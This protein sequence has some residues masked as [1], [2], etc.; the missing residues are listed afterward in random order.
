MMNAKQ[1]SEEVVAVAMPVKLTQDEEGLVVRFGM[2]PDQARVQSALNKEGRRQQWLE[3]AIDPWAKKHG[4]SRMQ[5]I[6]VLFCDNTD[7]VTDKNAYWA[8][9]NEF[10]GKTML[11]AGVKAYTPLGLRA[12]GASSGIPADWGNGLP[13]LD[14]P[15]RKGGMITIDVQMLADVL[16]RYNIVCNLAARLCNEMEDYPERPAAQFD[17]EELLHHAVSDYSTGIREELLDLIED[18]RQ[19]DTSPQNLTGKPRM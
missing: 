2:T 19:A 8:E 12:P 14:V 9:G 16:N 13:V 17:R 7:G 3:T 4:I 18:L 15:S 5:A 6:S 11:E 1:E 10:A